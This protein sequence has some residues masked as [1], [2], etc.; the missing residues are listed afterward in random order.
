MF[1]G[2]V[3]ALPAFVLVALS[4]MAA[5]A[6]TGCAIETAGLSL[7]DVRS[8]RLEVVEVSAAPGATFW[9]GNAEREFAANAA[10]P[11]GSQPKADKG[12]GKGESPPDS[13]E[14]YAALVASPEARAF[15][16]NKA[17]SLVKAKLT[18]DVLPRYQGTRRAK[19]VVVIQQFSIPSPIQR[20]TLGG[21]PV[22]IADVSVVDAVTGA[23]IAQ[24][25]KPLSAAAQAGNGLVGVMVDQAFSGLEERMAASFAQRVVLWLPANGGA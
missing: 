18:S 13:S 12:K 2:R 24:S 11:A 5:L 16:A 19:L 25:Q 9:W 7:S 6:L 8:L 10:G 15:M 23:R 20:A 1:A 21:V 14:R 17:S 4:L 3:A 22:M